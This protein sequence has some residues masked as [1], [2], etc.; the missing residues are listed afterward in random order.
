[1]TAEELV[2]QLRDTTRRDFDAI[3]S[4]HKNDK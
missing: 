1:M 4:D 2:Q 3:L